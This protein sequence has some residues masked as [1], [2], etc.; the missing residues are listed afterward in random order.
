MRPGLRAKIKPAMEMMASLPSVVLG[1]LAGAVVAP[2]VEGNIV[3]IVCTFFTVPAALV[4]A[5][6]PVAAVAATADACCCPLAAGDDVPDAAP[7]RAAGHRAW[8][9]GSSGRG[10]PATCVAWLDGQVGIGVGGWSD[11]AGAR[12]GSDA[13]GG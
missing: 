11:V 4:L 8:R 3:A 5:G 12:R 10:S 2:F 1:F 9:R 13:G 6:L 7:R